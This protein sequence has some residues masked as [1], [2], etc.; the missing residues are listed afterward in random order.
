MKPQVN[1]NHYNFESYESEAR[2]TSYFHQVKAV[3]MLCPESLL[4]VGKGSGFF[5]ALIRNMGVNVCT[6]DLAF[7]LKPTVVGSVLNLPFPDSS[8]DACVAFQMLEHI[9]FDEFGTAIS[10]LMRVSKKGIAIS[11]PDFGNIGIVLS[12]PYTRKLH[13]SHRALPIRPK[14]RFDGEHYWEINKSEYPLKRILRVIEQAG[15]VCQKTWL[16][17]YNPY[18]R[19][20]V[21]KK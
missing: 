14:H 18:H 10:E 11:L 12:I 3:N 8:L 13:F 5:T 17:P 9:P 7:D 19:F 16:N 4:E 1:K 6:L 2:F 21:I 15:F 20:F